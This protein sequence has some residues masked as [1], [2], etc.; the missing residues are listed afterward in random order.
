MIK[1]YKNTPKYRPKLN[2]VLI[3]SQ[4]RHSDISIANCNYVFTY[5]AVLN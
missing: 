2:K 1:I 3:E 5:K 4:Q